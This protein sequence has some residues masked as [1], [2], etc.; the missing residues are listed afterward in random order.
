M[1]ARLAGAS[2]RSRERI[3][4]ADRSGAGMGSGTTFSVPRSKSPTIISRGM[5]EM[6]SVACSIS[7]MK[8]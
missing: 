7:R 6:R 4:P 8:P 5:T 1:K 3:S 2:V